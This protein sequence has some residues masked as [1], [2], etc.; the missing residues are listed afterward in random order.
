VSVSSAQPILS[1]ITV[2]SYDSI[3]LEST[4]SSF[5]HLAELDVEH[6]TVLPR[7]DE[8]SITIWNDICGRL[9]NF[10]LFFDANEGIYS[11]MNVGGKE[12]LGKFLVFWNS[13]E[14][15]TSLV[16]VSLLLDRLRVC[17]AP[18]LISQGEIEWLP[19]H[20]QDLQS[21]QRFLLGDLGSFISHQTYFVN[22]EFFL[23]LCGF[24][25]RLS[26]ASDTDF[27]LRMSGYGIEIA[28]DVYPVWVENS[29]FASQN[30]RIARKEN[31]I[32]ALRF[33]LKMKS[34]RR[35]VN[36]IHSETVYLSEKFSLLYESSGWHYSPYVKALPK[37]YSK[38]LIRGKSS[39]GR[40]RAS[41]AFSEA[42]TT[43]LVSNSILNVGVI[44][45][46]L[47][48]IEVRWLLTQ[49]PELRIKVL[50]IEDFDVYLDLNRPSDQ[51]FDFDLVLVSQVLEHIWNH[52]TFFDNTLSSV[53]EG[54]LIWI[55]CPASNKMHAS[56]DYFSA[57]FTAQYLKNN[58]ELRN[59]KSLFFGGYGSKRLYLATHLIPGWLTPKGHSFP[60]FF[61]FEERAVVPRILLWF[62]FLPTLIFLSFV[63][64]G[65]SNNDRWYTESW[66]LGRK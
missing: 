21:Y 31:F 23:A 60:L 42:I 11:A 27:I 65:E 30:H 39:L 47:D 25:T 14:R 45:G 4:L 53:R 35:L 49:I 19:L 5:L 28:P 26:V 2:S 54:G 46:S 63:D 7:S 10:K 50:G 37:S 43:E 15:V 8:Q 57:G 36:A 33:L 12:A 6:I 51:R 24:S 52:K 18:Q 20:R 9:P 1:I 16:Q 56:P 61:A 17:E 64:A 55:G 41:Y 59:V 48:D 58:F 34:A 13:G 62:R 29:V 66:W 32:L 38:N 22:R 40:L 3:R 44:G